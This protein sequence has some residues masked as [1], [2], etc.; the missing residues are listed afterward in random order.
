MLPIKVFTRAR[1]L[2]SGFTIV[3]ISRS[4]AATSCS[5]GVNKKKL[6]RVTNVTFTSLR[7]RSSFSISK[8]AYMPPKPP[9][10]INTR[11]FWGP[12]LASFCSD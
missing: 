11:H 3:L 12:A 5:M 6:S 7:R 1:S 2:R 8:A 4:L 9:P 10:K